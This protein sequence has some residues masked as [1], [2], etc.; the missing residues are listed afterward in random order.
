MTDDIRDKLIAVLA[1]VDRDTCILFIAACR[2]RL[3]VLA[4]DELQDVLSSIP[5]YE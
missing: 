5:S 3:A 2:A 4:T 1:N